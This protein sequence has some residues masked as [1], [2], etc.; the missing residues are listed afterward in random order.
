MA[1]ISKLRGIRKSYLRN[2]SNQEKEILYLTESYLTEN[3]I[4]LKSH[5]NSL[6]EKIE[7]VKQLDD[8]I[9]ENLSETE[10]E[11]ELDTILN[12]SDKLHELLVHIDTCLAPKTIH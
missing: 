11:T 6:L 2:I 5:K 4:K 9:I 7:K 12:R 8:S 10:L 3:E 1:D